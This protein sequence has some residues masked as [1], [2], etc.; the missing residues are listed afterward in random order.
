M[1]WKCVE[2]GEVEMV[3]WRYF[4]GGKWKCVEVWKLWFVEEGRK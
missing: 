4:G 2:V 3:R 1:E